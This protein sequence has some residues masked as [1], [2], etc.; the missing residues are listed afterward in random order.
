VATHPRPSKCPISQV[1]LGEE[2]FAT[3]N[4]RAPAEVPEKVRGMYRAWEEVSDA[5][6]NDGGD[7]VTSREACT[8]IRETLRLCGYDLS[9]LDG[10]DHG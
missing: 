10:G 3:W 1:S 8:A 7:P 6:L 5:V 2:D 9:T 4:R